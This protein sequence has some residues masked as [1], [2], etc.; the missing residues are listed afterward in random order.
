MP[1]SKNA[2]QA[3][4]FDL[5]Y[6][7]ALATYIPSPFIVEQNDGVLNYI[8]K[9]ANPKTIAEFQ[10]ELDS[11][12]E[13]LISI[14]DKLTTKSILAKYK[15]K[16]KVAKN[17]ELL[18]GDR[19]FKKI[20]THFIHFSLESF[21]K[22]ISKTTIPLAINLNKEDIFHHY[23]VRFSPTVLEPKLHF[24]K[25]PE[26]I[27]YRLSLLDGETEFF[28]F[29]QE[30]KI[31][32]DQPS[33]VLCNNQIYAITHINGNKLKPFLT[34]KEVIIPNKNSIEYFNKFIKTVIRNVP[35]EAEGFSVITDTNCKGCIIKPSLSI[36]HKVYLLEVHFVYD[37]YTFSI[38]DNLLKMYLV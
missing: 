35:I 13:H 14:C 24:S 19:K 37:A 16:N 5:T 27:I 30:F 36:I 7:V 17:L 12:E 11:N 18:L 21:F 20:I 34:K 6:D 28:P 9:I 32:L 31:L 4:V 33:W 22:I 10:L 15:L 8:T 38:I 1:I 23:A 29:E 25:T 3:L 2:N 26:N